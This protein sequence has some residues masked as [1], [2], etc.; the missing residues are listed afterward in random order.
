MVAAVTSCDVPWQIVDPLQNDLRRAKYGLSMLSR[1]VSVTSRDRNQLDVS[2]LGNDRAANDCRDPQRYKIRVQGRLVQGALALLS[3]LILLALN[4]GRAQ[5]AD[6]TITFDDVPPTT[7]VETHYHSQGVDFG[8][9]PYGSLPPTSQV[10]AVWC[11]FPITRPAPTGYSSQVASIHEGGGEFYLAGLFGLFSTFR[12]HIQVTVGDSTQMD[13]S[14]VSLSIFNVNGALLGQSVGSV[15]GGSAPITLNVV[16]PGA[17]PD[18]AY[19]LIQSSEYNNQLWV[20]NLTFDNPTKGARPDFS[21]NAGLAGP[22]QAIFLTQGGVSALGLTLVRF[23]GSNGNIA[24]SAIG[25]PSG[26]TAAFVP[27][28]LSGI[29]TSTELGLVADPNAPAVTAPFT[30]L[31]VPSS[32]KV[33]PAPR[34]AQYYLT[35]TPPAAIYTSGWG[36]VYTFPSCSLGTI[37]PIYV[38]KDPAVVPSD[39]LLALR[40]PDGNGGTTALPSGIHASFAPAVSP[41]SSPFTTHSLSLSIDGGALKAGKQLDVVVVG[42]SGS[43]TFLSQAFTLQGNADGIDTITPSVA[44]IPNNTLGTP[45]TKVTITGTG[46]CPGLKV[47][48]GNAMAVVTPDSLSPTQVVA[49]VPSLATVPDSPSS[50]IS[51]NRVDGSVLIASPSTTFFIDSVRNTAGYSFHNYIPHTTFDELTAA[52]GSSETEDQVPL[53]WPFDCT[54]SWHD[55]LA[56]TWLNILQKWTDAPGGGGACFGIAL[57]SARF[58]SGQAALGNFP[59]QPAPFLNVFSLDAPDPAGPSPDLTSYIDSQDTVQISQEYASEYLQQSVLNS[60]GNTSDVLLEIHK[61]I[62]ASIAAGELPLIALRF[63]GSGHLVTAYD[64]EDV[65]TN[66]IEYYIDV[67]DPNDPFTATENSNTDGKTHQTNVQQSRIHI[68]PDGTWGLQDNNNATGFINGLIVTPASSIPLNP[69]LP[70]SNPTSP[71][72]NAPITIF[73]SVGGEGSPVSLTRTRTTQLTDNAGHTLF[74]ADGKLNGNRVSRLNATPYSLMGNAVGAELFLVGPESGPVVQ[75]IVGVRAGADS[76]FIASG[77]LL[78]RVETTASPGIQDRIGFD[79]AGMVSF[80]TRGAAKPLSIGLSARAEG[81]VRSA[82]ITTVATRDAPDELSFDRTQTRIVLRHD[83]PG[84]MLRVRFSTLAIEGGP[85]SFN[86]GPIEIGAGQVVTF[87]PLDWTR[88]DTVAM[89]VF[90]PSGKERKTFLQDRAVKSPASII[91]D[92][93]V[94]H[95]KD[96][97]RMRSIDVTSRIAAL[98]PDDQIVITWIVRYGGHIVAHEARL[99]GSAEVHPGVRRDK[100]VFAAPVEGLYDVRAELV[101]RKV[102]GLISVATRSAKSVRFYIK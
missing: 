56:I 20:D 96:K 40:V 74:A 35:I 41:R 99:L 61:A 42:T 27:N 82:V 18:I 84:T 54:V 92:L 9:P 65:S 69:T 94:R 67:Y 15:S 43:F 62:H 25:L 13:T 44:S 59:S 38:S 7:P 78:A 10:P 79:P 60:T 72:A 71:F 6:T 1:I 3:L 98:H 37:G 26:V 73:G 100:Y 76:H 5:C 87:A 68:A 63:G 49:T 50:P 33:G 86:S 101:V 32:A 36:A 89:E 64:I 102:N 51:L 19:F 22:G 16:A 66:P 24:L 90:Q 97:E 12:K 47:Q 53:C 4:C 45:G 88:L 39:V 48:F 55:P 52:Y 30:L 14:Q 75:S 81:I 70:G 95:A 93:D 31:G 28:L 57:S 11:C 46:F 23:N 58:R 29:A 34:T 77:G 21:F 85:V 80:A 8:L 83:G 91:V 17:M 2:E